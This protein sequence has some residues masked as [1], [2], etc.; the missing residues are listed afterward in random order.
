M[1][2][3]LNIKKVFALSYLFKRFESDIVCLIQKINC[4]TKQKTRKTSQRVQNANIDSIL[5]T[6][7]EISH[8]LFIVIWRP[9]N[10]AR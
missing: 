4:R 9:V 8:S 10:S 1:S 5:H 7:G 6:S 2:N 3:I